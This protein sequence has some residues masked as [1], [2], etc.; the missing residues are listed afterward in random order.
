MDDQAAGDPEIEWTLTAGTY[1]LEVAVRED[2]T[3]A[4]AIAIVSVPQ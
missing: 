4:D 2:G 3:L 1:T